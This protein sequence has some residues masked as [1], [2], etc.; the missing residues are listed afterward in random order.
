METLIQQTFSVCGGK[1]THTLINLDYIIH[2]SGDG[3]KGYLS[4]QQLK[5][6]LDPKGLHLFEQFVNR[7][8]KN[9]DNTVCKLRSGVRVYFNM[10]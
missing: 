2:F 5:E 8:Y 9:G 3:R 4:S 7:A 10:R 1:I 6:L